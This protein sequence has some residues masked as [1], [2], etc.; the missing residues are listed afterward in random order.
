MGTADAFANGCVVYGSRVIGLLLA[1][2]AAQPMPTSKAAT[3]PSSP[4]VAEL[5]RGFAAYRAG[6]YHGAV[7]ILRAA[8]TKGSSNALATTSIAASVS[9]GVT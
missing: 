5:G 1:L 2:L 3:T 9:A 6:D 4:A 8:A 7:P